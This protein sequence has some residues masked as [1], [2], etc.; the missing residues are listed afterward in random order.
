MGRLA[1]GMVNALATLAGTGRPVRDARRA[2]VQRSLASPSCPS[3]SPD[4]E[5]GHRSERV[6][7]LLITLEAL[8]AAPE[9]LQTDRH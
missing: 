8:Q 5:A 9:V 1:T 4:P 3:S 6:L 7:S 2:E